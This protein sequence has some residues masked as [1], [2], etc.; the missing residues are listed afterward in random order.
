MFPPLRP[1]II[2]KRKQPF[3]ST[4]ISLSVKLILSLPISL[5]LYLS[6]LQSAI[7]NSQSEIVFIF[8][9]PPY[10]PG[11]IGCPV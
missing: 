2:D 4:Q 1:L 10:L 11:V 5:S 3:Y 9:L 8:A 7:R 6:F